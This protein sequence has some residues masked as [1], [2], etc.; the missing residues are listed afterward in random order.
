MTRK[1]SKSLFVIFAILLVICLIACFVNFTYPFSIG[2]NYY[3]YSNFVSNIKLG[4]DVG[5]SLRIVYRAELPENESETNYNNLKQST[6]N[7]LKDIVKSQGYKDVSVAEYGDNHIALTIGNI[8]DEE[9]IS[10]IQFLIGNP[11]TISFSKNSDGSEPFAKNECIKSVKTTSMSN[12]G[13]MYY[14]VLLE[15][16]DDFKA[17]IAEISAENKIYVYIGEQEFISGG[18]TEGAITEEGTLPLS[19]DTWTNDMQAQTV[20][21]QIKT[22]TLPLSLTQ[23]VSDTISAS[24]GVGANVMLS[25]AITIMVL[26][27]FVFMVVKYKHMGWLTNFAMLFFIVIS[28]FLLQSIPTIHMNFGGFIGFVIC[29]FFAMDSILAILETAKKHYQED[30]KLHIAFKMSLKEN[31]VRTFINNCLLIV[32]GFICMFIP[33]LAVKSFGWV[34]FIMPM[35]S[36]FVSV[37]LMRLFIKMYLALNSEDGKKCNFHKGGKNA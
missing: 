14:Y 22:G 2:G 24:Y 30:T 17:E 9:D 8:L 16:K 36:L 7:K 31:F 20:A 21:N 11:A 3:S 37:A 33:S 1:R 15:F 6:M 27:G 25:V 5:N 29:L 13:K 23:T 18:L 34:A 35:V 12:E 4:E 28:L 19:S 10:T 26:I 32:A